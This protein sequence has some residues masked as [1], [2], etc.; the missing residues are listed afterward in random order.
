MKKFKFPRIY[1]P[2]LSLTFDVGFMA[3]NTDIWRNPIERDCFD[4]IMLRWKFFKWNGKFNLYRP[5]YT[6]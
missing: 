5:G 1:K 6:L 2:Y 3:F 4:Y